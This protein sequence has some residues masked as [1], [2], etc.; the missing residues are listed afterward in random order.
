[1]KRIL[2]TL[3][4][5]SFLWPMSLLAD[6][7]SFQTPDFAFPK[8]VE[9]NASA[10]LDKALADGD[11]ATAVRA[12]VQV[13]Q[14]R[15][16]VS[17]HEMTDALNL[18][19]S[20]MQVGNLSAD[21][22]ALLF[23]CKSEFVGHLP[24]KEKGDDIAADISL[25]SQDK[26]DSLQ[27]ALLDLAIDPLG[28]GEIDALLKPIKQYKN[29]MKPGDEL[30]GRCLPLLYDFLAYKRL[31]T[32]MRSKEMTDE[33]QQK[34]GKKWLS[35]HTKDTDLFPSLFIEHTRH[36][37][38]EWAPQDSIIL[39]YRDREEIGLLYYLNERQS[40]EK[41]LWYD[42]YRDYVN[43][44]PRSPFVPYMKSQ[45][46][47]WDIITV[48]VMFPKLI[49]SQQGLPA[50]LRSYSGNSARCK[51]SVYRFPDEMV[52]PEKAPSDKDEDK[53]IHLSQL[54]LVD[55][56]IVELNVKHGDDPWD[57]GTDFKLNPLPYGV[58]LLSTAIQTP[59][60]KWSR[61]T[62]LQQ[63][64]A[65]TFTVS[66]IRTFHIKK[67]KNIQLF[68]IDAND[69]HP[70]A[71]VDV[72]YNLNQRHSSRDDGRFIKNCKSAKTNSEGCFSLE[73]TDFVEYSLT[74]DEDKYLPA[75]FSRSIHNIH[76]YKGYNGTNIPSGEIFTDLAIY[77]PGE[78]VHATAVLYSA[79]ATKREP[80]SN[81]C[82]FKFYNTNRN[83]IEEKTER[84]D[85]WGQ[86]SADFQIPA[87]RMNGYYLLEV[88]IEG[89]SPRTIV[90]KGISVS[91]YKAPTF[92]IDLSD[93]KAHQAQDSATVV[94]GKITTF[95]GMPVAHCE[96]RCNWTLNALYRTLGEHKFS[97]KTDEQGNFEC[98]C[99]KNWNK[100]KKNWFGFLNARISAECT[101]KA[102]ETQ[103]AYCTVQLVEY[104]RIDMPDPDQRDGHTF[105]LPT[106]APLRLPIS[107]SSTR[108]DETSATCHYTLADKETKKIVAE[109]DFSS[110][111]PLF[112]WR[113][114]PSG[115]YTF[116]ADIKDD[117]NAIGIKQDI[118][119]Y[120]A[121]DEM[122]P[123]N[124]QGLWMPREM[125]SVTEQGKARIL[126]GCHRSCHI[127]YIASSRTKILQ[128]GWLDYFA[129]THW[130]EMPMPM[131]KDEVLTVEFYTSIDGQ[132]AWDNE[133]KL[134]S[135]MKDVVQ[136]KTV[137]FRDKVVPSSRQHWTFQLADAEG[138]P[139]KGR[140]MLELYQMALEK[141]S[142]NKWSFNPRYAYRSC[143]SARYSDR[144]LIESGSEQY[145][146]EGVDIKYVPLTLAQCTMLHPK[147]MTRLSYGNIFDGIAGIEALQ[148]RISGIDLGGSSRRRLKKATA[149]NAVAASL[150]IVEDDTV[151]EEEEIVMTSNLSQGNA[152][153]ALSSLPVR[154]TQTHVAL[155]R[156][157][158]TAG[159]DGTF[160]LDFDLPDENATWILQALAYTKTLA[161]DVLR[162]EIVAQ[163]PVMVQ[164]SLPRFLRTGDETTLLANVQNATDSTLH[165]TALVELFDPRTEAVLSSRT[166]TLDIAAHGTQTVGIECRAMANAP[167]VGFRIRAVAADGNGDG[168]QQRIPILPATSPVTEAQPFYLAGGQASTTLDVTRPSAENRRS[169]LLACSNPTWHCISA[170]PS[171]ANADAVTSTGLAHS[172]FARALA[173]T[174]IDTL[175]DLPQMSALRRNADLRIGMLQASPW[176][177]D[178]EWQ[179]RRIAAIG[180]LLD[181]VA[182]ADALA[183]LYDKLRSM[184]TAD[185]GFL[186]IGDAK[187]SSAKASLWAT[188]TVV[189]LVGELCKLGALP[190]AGKWLDIVRPALHFIDRETSAIEQDQKKSN[191]K[192]DYL[193]FADYAY[194]RQL[195]DG[196]VGFASADAE[197][198]ASDII[199]RTTN[200]LAERWRE[201]SLPDR[202]SAAIILNRNGRTDEAR[203]IVESLRQM[204]VVT[205]QRGM[206]WERIGQG[207]WFH[208]VACTAAVLEA[209]NEVA[210]D[211][212]ARS[213]EAIRQW[214]LLEKQTSDWGTSSMAAHA[215]YVLLR[216]GDDWL[217][218][219][220][221]TT[222]R[223]DIRLNGAPLSWQPEHAA[224]GDIRLTLADT[225]RTVS[226]G[227]NAPNPAW[228]AVVHQYEAPMQS[229]TADAT[230]ELRIRKE[231]WVEAADGSWSK[232]PVAADG[233][234]QFHVGQR[235][236]VRL[237]IVCSKA[238]EYLTLADERPAFLEPVDQTSGY[239]WDGTFHYLETKDSQTHL[240]FT[241]LAEG[242][243]VATYDCHVTNSGHFAVGIA[244]IQSQ[245]APQ[246]VAH[247]AGGEAESR[248]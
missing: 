61:R 145:P 105:C 232:A 155:W 10:A 160:S 35:L 53:K 13:A 171:L 154:S 93:T 16:I 180:Q 229:V 240:Y 141:L 242:S 200:A 1:M 50:T 28:N 20:V 96:V 202:A 221:D 46:A 170:L 113:A 69:G 175:P 47:E 55:E 106:D 112:D 176:L 116:K 123:L 111:E 172:L 100:A 98:T 210:A 122:P 43:R 201:L 110:D 151:I 131:E 204:A 32:Q 41:E 86:A 246:F 45:I 197:R 233:S 142:S 51:I 24:Y 87:D 62:S 15:L 143:Y 66:D 37:A 158:L 206:Y 22:K 4:L 72:L 73:K 17:E 227:H 25:W 181:S 68:A 14:A 177:P 36:G 59:Q 99:P 165:V 18:I 182:N 238:L 223:L 107:F 129:G 30:G 27:N 135:P 140:M 81:Q 243:H 7:N 42:I 237:V 231:F 8:D 114:L 196:K 49:S 245:Y 152:T 67:E 247:S 138:R 179:E 52:F 127:Y 90:Q 57:T 248:K 71:D 109:G 82:K 31:S 3:I 103:T 120:R 216:T 78:T 117:A 174:L 228:G 209:F 60:G 244:T 39:K 211:A 95:S 187:G 213:I 148:G 195:F 48:D 234:L 44:F 207:T 235:V 226:I 101:D 168:E 217:G 205:P 56:Q 166:E 92:Q 241:R 157:T 128:E 137:T 118:I 147:V 194:T 11:Q 80:W 153:D 121:S 191:E 33:E 108:S 76:H 144:S 199:R 5:L 132:C 34:I 83:L 167:Y 146:Q 77:R 38:Q 173:A 220:S 6:T 150:S 2:S 149:K 161:A 189:Q 64:E 139:I 19:D 26:R 208:P 236:Q 133:V 65:K 84:S 74:D 225:V 186:W 163:R 97:V 136:L 192:V 218:S 104:R 190:S 239:R 75:K 29:I 94:R 178:A 124:Y 188:T 215:I 159:D 198:R 79:S 102:G 125:Q 130:F 214:L 119:I 185:G 193:T 21:Y 70:L 162:R 156:P 164:P 89:D 91:E 88:S 115:C 230:D 212:E 40:P 203:R 222:T 9:A 126:L 58:Y 169:T 183:Q 219:A 85:E 23:F 63:W 12:V 54:K 134:Y 224:L 184:Q